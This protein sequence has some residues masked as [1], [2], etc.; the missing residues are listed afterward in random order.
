MRILVLSQYFW[1][2]PFRVTDLVSALHA[3]GHEVTVLTGWPNYPEGRVYPDFRA[4][5]ARFA[6]HGA[7]DVLRVPLLP[8]GQGALRLMLNYAVFVVSASLVGPWKLRGLKFDVIFVYQPSPI[9]QCIPALVVGW[10]KRAPVLLWTLD[11]WPETLIAVGAVRRPAALR[12]VSWIVSAIYRRC[13]LVLGQS[14]AFEESVTR[15]SGGPERFRY[16]PQWS[17]PLFDGGLDGVVPAPEVQPFLGSFNVVFA[18]NIGEA[19]DFPVILEAAE[20]LRNR[21]DI[22]WLIIGDGRAA[23]DARA[24]VAARGLGERVHFLGRHPIE[25][26]PAFFVAAGALLVTLKRDPVFARV[27]PGKVQTYLAAGL[28]IVGMLDGE[29]A[30]VLKESGAARV[31]PS[32][33]AET[34]ARN[35]A[36]L[37][38][39]PQGERAAIGARGAAYAARE[40]DRDR[41]LAQ[42]EIWCA[43]VAR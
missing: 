18:G 4:D 33:D 2:E 12:A 26:I 15:H 22:K 36:S 5:P 1:P 6:R 24:Q 10:M 25:R 3:R 37:A 16:F 27:I 11:L 28:P 40:F 42:L 13:A 43:E 8:R 38:D 21:T 19:Q 23:A 32:G 7:S 31:G 41:L 9:T 14:R 34:L 29:G 35:V 39:T 30:R 17:E 20:R